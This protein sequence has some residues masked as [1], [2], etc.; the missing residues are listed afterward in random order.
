MN[1]D[2][3]KF[4]PFFRQGAVQLSWTHLK[5]IGTPIVGEYF[6]KCPGRNGSEGN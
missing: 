2:F 6:C 5:E 4:E 3:G 1:S